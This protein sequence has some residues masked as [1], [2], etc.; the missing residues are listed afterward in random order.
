[1]CKRFLYGDRRRFQRIGRN[2][3]GWRLSESNANQNRYSQENIDQETQYIGSYDTPT[4]DTEFQNFASL[5]IKASRI[6]MWAAFRAASKQADFAIQ[7]VDR[8]H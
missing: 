2:R 4:R 7:R 1:M 8:R 6:S 3:C 5:Q